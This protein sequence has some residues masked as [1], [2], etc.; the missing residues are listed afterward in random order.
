MT[1]W[2]TVHNEHELAVLAMKRTG[3]H[4]VIH[5]LLSHFYGPC[6]HLNNG[7]FFRREQHVNPPPRLIS[8]TEVH[9][10]F[11]GLSSVFYFDGTFQGPVRHVLAHEQFP[12]NE[13]RIKACQNVEAALRLAYRVGDQLEAYLF[14]LEDMHVRTFR[15][16]SPALTARG[17]SQHRHQVLVVRDLPNFVASRLAGGYLITPAVIDAWASHVRLALDAPDDW[18]VVRFPDWHRSAS[19]RRGI[20]ASLGLDRS[21]AGREQVLPFGPVGRPGSSFDGQS[22]SGRASM[23]DITERWRGFVDDPRWQEICGD[24]ELRSLSNACFGDPTEHP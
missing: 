19:T 24:P 9:E 11:S 15:S 3:H 21:D 14:N 10:D 4:A 6:V 7:E 2:E 20:S 17:T 5:W 8:R 13:A 12:S 22:Y 18:V 16:L 23:M 1:P